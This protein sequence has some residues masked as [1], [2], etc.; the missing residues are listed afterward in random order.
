LGSAFDE[1][2]A[3][4]VSVGVASSRGGGAATDL[5]A[6]ADRAMYQH[7]RRPERDAVAEITLA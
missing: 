6:R 3:A 2:L 5:L 7:K 1:G 4:R